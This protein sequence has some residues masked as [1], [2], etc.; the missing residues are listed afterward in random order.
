[1]EELIKKF[2]ENNYEKTTNN[3]ERIKPQDIKNKFNK[4]CKKKYKFLNDISRQQVNKI[5]TELGYAKSK[6]QGVMY[7]GNIIPK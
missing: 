7:Y 5:M 1:M 4:D 2:I 6:V 3:L